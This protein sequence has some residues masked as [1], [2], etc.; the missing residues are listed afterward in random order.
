VTPT[1]L[2]KLA[3]D[4]RFIPGI[5]NYCDRW[6]ERCPLSHRCL[7]YAMEKAEDDDDPAGRDLANQ[8]FWNKLHSNFHLTMQMIQ[9]DAQRLGV[10][11]NAP[12]AMCEAAAHERHVRRRAGRNQPLSR[13]AR[14]YGLAAQK[15]FEDSAALF[16]DK[17]VELAKQAHLEIGRPL[18]EAEEIREMLD[19]LQWYH[20]F[21][22]VKLTRAIA[23]QA[24]EELETDPAMRQFP[25]DSDGSTKIALI[26]MDR[27][28][29]AWTELCLHFPEQ[30]DAILDFQLRLARIRGETER[31]F[32]NARAFFRPGFDEDMARLEAGG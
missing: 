24:E 22:H 6:C 29:L 15:W 17:G 18:D 14:D 12:D 21:I 11:L 5:Y 31:F 27:S 8:K 23:S 32:P 4:P 2:R 25:R 30:E 3:A 26:G 28:L 7:N 20:L 13:A 16:R 9:E 1:Q 10:D 19:I